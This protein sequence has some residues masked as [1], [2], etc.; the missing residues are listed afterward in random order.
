[1]GGRLFGRWTF[2]W[3]ATKTHKTSS[4]YISGNFSRAKS[5]KEPYLYFKLGFSVVIV[6]V[7][8]ILGLIVG[9]SRFLDLLIV[10][11]NVHRISISLRDGYLLGDIF[12]VAP[13][14]SWEDVLPA[15]ILVL[16]P[17]T[18]AAVRH[19][20]FHHLSGKWS[21]GSHGWFSSQLFV[22]FAGAGSDVRNGNSPWVTDQTMSG[23][24][25]VVVFFSGESIHNS[26]QLGTIKKHIVACIP[27]SSS[28]SSS[29]SSSPSSSSSSS[30][31]SF[32]QII[33]TSHDLTPNGSKWWFSKG[34]PLI[35]GVK[36]YNLA[37]SSSSS[38]PS[39]P[40]QVQSALHM[41]VNKR[42]NSNA[43]V[44]PGGESEVWE[45]WLGVMEWWRDV[46]IFHLAMDSGRFEKSPKNFQVVWYCWWTKFCTTWDV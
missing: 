2:G 46:V 28:S 37:R 32:G 44:D 31:S 23:E 40:S 34:N 25:A 9:L 8:R 3:K 7:L 17:H 41:G 21:H 19:G 6:V 33:T 11:L 27:P 4:F 42:R 10:L 20:R 45:L 39:S 30:S 36:Y 12:V 35:S 24:T 15:C 22:K 14:A 5:C 1:M 13:L 29:A 16:P 26:K 38:S 43:N 18:T